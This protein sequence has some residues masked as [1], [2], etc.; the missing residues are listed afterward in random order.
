MFLAVCLTVLSIATSPAQDAKTITLQSA[1]DLAVEKN[2]TVIQARNTLEAAQ[3]SHT[4]AVG[5][6]LPNLDLTGSFSRSQTW[7]NQAAGVV[8]YQGIPIPVGSGTDFRANNSFSSGISSQVVLF[9]GFANTSG[10]SRATSSENAA[11]RSLDR[12]LQ[13]TI[14]QTNQLFLG[15]VQTFELL[16]VNQ[17]NLKR[18]E[19]QLERITESNKVGAVAVAD[20]YRQKVQVGSDELALIQAESNHE[21]A[22]AD[23]IAYIGVDFDKEYKF[24][25]TGIPDSIDTTEFAS[26]NAQYANFDNLYNT[27]LGKRPDYLAAVETYNA[28]D[29]GVSVA[30]AG[31]YPTVSLF[32]SYGYNNTELSNLTDNRNLY[33][34]VNVNLPIFSGFST[35]NSIEQA[36]VQKRNA[37]EQVKQS[38]RQLRVDVRKA[39]L[40]L[41]AAEK[42]VSVTQSSVVSATMDRAI[43]EEKY[44]LGA[45]TLLDLLVATANYTT[46]LSN[47]VNAVT[48]YLLAKK[49]TEYALGSLAK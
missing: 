45:G 25:F 41:E 11:D 2:L 42:A 17:D 37:D 23:L 7:S 32:G 30:R 33:F 24:D 21:K 13:G 10:V 34:A 35:Q 19:R 40:D 39:L 16:K 8:F 22:K 47:K 20:V 14:Y 1:V 31:W 27:A 46:T 6:M 48:G 29:A 12:T 49:A 5:A 18:S 9:N 28:A 36:Q 15:V 38:A 44:N 4:A 3:S 26:V 43:A